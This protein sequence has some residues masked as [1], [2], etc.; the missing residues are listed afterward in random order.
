MLT[1][2]S[3]QLIAIVTMFIDHLGVYIFHSP[4]WMRAIGRLAMPLYCFMLSEGFLHTKGKQR[5]RYFGRLLAFAFIS[6]LPFDLAHYAASGGQLSGLPLHLSAGLMEYKLYLNVI[7]TLLFGF[8]AMSAIEYGGWTAI[9][10]SIL[11]LFAE[12]LGMDYGVYG[13]LLVINF[14][15]CSRFLK[16]EKLKI[17]RMFGYMFS[18]F[19]PM[20]LMV[21][22]ENKP[23]QLFSLLAIFPILMYGGK[24][25]HRLPKWF[26]YIFYPAHLMAIAIICFLLPT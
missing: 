9:Y 11:L 19:V 14:Y 8:I 2:A 25:G 13:V 21:I 7:F 22:I 16:G 10:L 17:G 20:T 6:Q 23:M 24:L 5:T 3:L 1:S 12:I 15:L 18:L 4:I 26:G